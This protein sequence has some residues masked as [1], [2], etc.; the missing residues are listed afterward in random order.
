[1]LDCMLGLLLTGLLPWPCAQ[2]IPTPGYSVQQLM[3]DTNKPVLLLAVFNIFSAA[4]LAARN[5]TAEWSARP[6]S[7]LKLYDK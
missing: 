2:A 3:A 6:G 4:L 7:A 1:M 5:E